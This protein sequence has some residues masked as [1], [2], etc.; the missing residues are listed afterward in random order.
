M[1]VLGQ[2]ATSAHGRSRSALSRRTDIGW[3]LEAIARAIRADAAVFA[4]LVDAKDEAAA[5]FYRLHGFEVFSG[6][7]G[8][9]FL[10][11]RHLG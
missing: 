9:M 11:V 4:F 10:P 3:R 8:R 7:A 2:K 5:R 6:K 1:S